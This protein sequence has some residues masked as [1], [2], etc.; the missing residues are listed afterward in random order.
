[1]NYT[2][3]ITYYIIKYFVV[4][5]II[6]IEV[7]HDFTRIYRI[8]YVC[9]N[10]GSEKIIQYKK[11]ISVRDKPLPYGFFFKDKISR[12]ARNDKKGVFARNDKK[13]GFD[14]KDKRSI[15]SE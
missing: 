8:L 2:L 10:L 14:R 6:E 13:R 12:F 4:L 15:R 9:K 3:A 11:V 1:V 5:S 7:L